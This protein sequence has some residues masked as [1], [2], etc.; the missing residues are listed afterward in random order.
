MKLVERLAPSILKMSNRRVLGAIFVSNPNYKPFIEDDNLAV[1]I[2]N[3]C[4]FMKPCGWIHSE[5]IIS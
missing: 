1:G 2:L 3:L 5:V 4:R